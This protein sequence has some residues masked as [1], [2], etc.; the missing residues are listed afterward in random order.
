MQYTERNFN[1]ALTTPSLKL[2]KDKRLILSSPLICTLI[3]SILQEQA[4][5]EK[6]VSG[7][8]QIQVWYRDDTNELVVNLLAA[9]DLALRDDSKRK[10]FKKF[11]L[12]LSKN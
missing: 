3:F 6:Q 7:R 1:V 10:M 11:L 9:D 12:G 5:K 4:I 2:L 8:V